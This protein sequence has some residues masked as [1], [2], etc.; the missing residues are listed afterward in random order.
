V[1]TVHCIQ[2]RWAVQ[3]VGYG[4]GYV[5]DKLLKKKKNYFWEDA[6]GTAAVY[7]AA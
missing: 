7:I 1:P 2:D 5:R 3:H 6:S 4:N